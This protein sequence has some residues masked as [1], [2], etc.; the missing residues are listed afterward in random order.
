MFVYTQDDI[1][2]FSITGGI[3][4]YYEKGG[5]FTGG[6][7]TRGICSGGIFTWWHYYLHSPY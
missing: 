1:Y 3:F 4:T 2:P 6:I 7:L 5:I